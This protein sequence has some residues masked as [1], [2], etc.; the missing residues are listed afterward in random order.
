MDVAITTSGAR[1]KTKKKRMSP[2][3]DV[4]CIMGQAE[5]QRAYST[6]SFLLRIFSMKF[7]HYIE[8]VLHAMNC[9]A[10]VTHFLA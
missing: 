10:L 3:P 4:W 8:K 9:E 2:G 1:E 5:A 7:F 6:G